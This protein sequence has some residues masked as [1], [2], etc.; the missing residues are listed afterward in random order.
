MSL[1]SILFSILVFLTE[2][3]SQPFYSSLLYKHSRNTITPC[4]MSSS[5]KAV[6]HHWREK[7]FEVFPGNPPWH[8]LTSYANGAK[9]KKGNA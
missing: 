1:I 3:H 5:G 7:K 4:K 6:D 8:L 9:G 2:I